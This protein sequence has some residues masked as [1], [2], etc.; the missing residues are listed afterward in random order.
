[1]KISHLQEGS[2][3]SMPSATQ[4]A[5]RSGRDPRVLEVSTPNTDAGGPKFARD[6]KVLET[7]AGATGSG[8][9]ATVSTPVG[10]TIS[11]NASIYGKTPK[12]SMLKG[13]KTSKK[14][15]NSAHVNESLDIPLNKIDPPD[16]GEPEGDFVKNQLHTIKRVT[17]HLER[18]VGNNED[19]PEWVEMKSAKLRA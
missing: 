17:S 10:A 8:S 1:M 19:L 5:F 7:S 14:Y 2:E 6:P 12:G 4:P 3:A 15:A 11:R 16:H 9:V 18:I 13:I